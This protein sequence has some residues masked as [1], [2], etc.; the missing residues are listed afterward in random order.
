MKK[1]L[2]SVFSLFL[3]ELCLSAQEKAYLFSYFINKSRDGLHLAYSYDGLKWTPLNYG[4]SFL[5]ANVGEERLMRESIIVQAP[6][7]TFHMV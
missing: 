4:R 6:D 7:G 3:S 1:L 2:I 5:V